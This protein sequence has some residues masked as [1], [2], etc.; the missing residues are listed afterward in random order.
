MRTAF[1]WVGEKPMIRKL[2][3]YGSSFHLVKKEK[4]KRNILTERTEETLQLS[5]T[6][7]AIHNKIE[8]TRNCTYP[9]ILGKWNSG[10]FNLHSV[11]VYV[12]VSF[13]GCMMKTFVWN[14]YLWVFECIFLCVCASGFMCGKKEVRLLSFKPEVTH[15]Y[16]LETHKE[17]RVLL[18]W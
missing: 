11:F 14:Q 4:K 1:S 9:Y 5:M 12:C 8:R 16:C 17:K 3:G 18:L 7:R 2:T 10:E 13:S 15:F 6:S